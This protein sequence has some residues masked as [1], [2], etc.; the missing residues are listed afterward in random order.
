MPG[1]TTI[2]ARFEIT[3]WDETTYDEPA[4][5]PKLTR[6]TVRKRFTGDLDGT[7]VTELLTAQGEGGRGYVASERITG[8]IDGRTGTFVL[9]HGGIDGAGETTTFGT[10][11]AGSGTGGLAGIAGTSRYV[12]DESGATLTLELNR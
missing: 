1:M 5:G 3:G 8:T 11:V 6:A 10:I 2:T 4:E 9:Q 7:S 12:H